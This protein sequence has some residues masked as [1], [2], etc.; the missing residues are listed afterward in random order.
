LEHIFHSMFLLMTVYCRDS[1]PVPK[2]GQ[3]SPFLIDSWSAMLQTRANFSNFMAIY[4]LFTSVFQCYT[5]YWFSVTFAIVAGLLRL[6]VLNSSASSLFPLFFIKNGNNSSCYC[7]NV[8]ILLSNI[9]QQSQP[10]LGYVISCFC[11]Q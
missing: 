4:Y 3:Y 7:E 5:G 2:L 6:Q 1:L 10:L 8:H 11:F 9:L